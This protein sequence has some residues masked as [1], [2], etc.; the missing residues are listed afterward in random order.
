MDPLEGVQNL[1]PEFQT[2]FQKAVEA[3][4][5][6]LTVLNTDKERLDK[7]IALISDVLGRIGKVQEIIPDFATPTNIRNPLVTSSIDSVVSGTA[8]KARASFGSH[9]IEVLQ[10][11]SPASA[12]SNGF[13]DKDETTVGSGFFVFETA[14]GEEKEVFIDNDSGT[15]Q[16]LANTINSAN[17]DVKASVINDTRDLD[18]PWRLVLTHEK[19]GSNNTVEYPV[20]YFV[21][22]EEELYL[23]A[24]ENAKS[25]KFR[26]QGLELESPTND[27]VDLVPGVTINLKGISETGRPAKLTV[28]QDVEKTK[29]RL[30]EL[31]DNVNSV[32]TFVK[33]Q[34]E[35]DKDKALGT[36]AGDYGIRFT[37]QRMV[38]ALQSSTFT[39][40]PNKTIRSLGTMGIEFNKE[41]TLVF[42]EKKV[43]NAINGHFDEVVE[44]LAGDGRGTGVVPR[45]RE[46]L[47]QITTPET[48]LLTAQKKTMTDRLKSVQQ[49]IQRTEARVEKK[50]EALKVKLARAQ[51]AISQ[52]E[53]QA[54]R[55]DAIG[56]G[57]G[58][59]IP[60]MA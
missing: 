50:A 18:A 45:L 57:G 7:K 47:D 15:L 24:E 12:V 10:L 46:V 29:A 6:P 51:A 35:A 28:A 23:D 59:I 22:G 8:D 56:S 36:L 16:G 52:I 19:T 21:D 3:E 2:A 43:E 54:A 38:N 26:F 39:A 20:F 53:Q 30:K 1:S 48:G 55:I 32:L 31:V 13:A 4:A 40:D 41:G 33:E 60:G 27:V 44:L 14:A 5:R 58:T 49:N 42:D 17:L 34:N 25:A 9:N 11:A 37:K